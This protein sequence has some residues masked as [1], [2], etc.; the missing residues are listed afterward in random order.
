MNQSLH[1]HSQDPDIRWDMADLLCWR[2]QLR[3]VW[4]DAREKK[5]MIEGG[6]FKREL[7][8]SGANGNQS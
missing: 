3:E 5:A 4:N 2:L 8:K 7:E 6:E 1:Q